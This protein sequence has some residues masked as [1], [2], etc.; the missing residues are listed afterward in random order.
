M[1]KPIVAVVQHKL[2]VTKT[3]DELLTYYHRFLRIAKTKGSKLV[4]FPEFSGLAVGIPMLPG[5][6]NALLKE[7]ATPKSGLLPKLKGMLAGGAANVVRADL[8]KSLLMTLEQMPE[9]LLDIYISVFSELA[10]QYE[11]TLV[12]GSLYVY[13]EEGAAIRHAAYVFG[14]DGAVL[15]RQMQV[16][17]DS[18]TLPV[19]VPGTG[20]QPIETSVG[21]LGILFAHEALY[22]EPARVLAYQG[23]DILITIA[24]TKRPAI[25]HKV[26]QGAL[27]RCQENQLYGLVSFLVG[28]DPFA[29]SDD[30]PLFLG[31]STIFAPLDFT[32]RFTG[33]MTELGSAQAEG[34]VTAEWDFPALHELWES[35]E[36]PIRRVMPL[37][38]VGLLAQVY[39]RALT[40]ETSA[41]SVHQIGAEELSEPFLPVPS[42]AEEPLAEPEASESHEAHPTPL[43]EDDLLA[44]VTPILPTEPPI[45]ALADGELEV[46]ETAVTPEDGDAVV[47]TEVMESEP[48]VSE[49]AMP[50]PSEMD[51]ET[52][53]VTA[54]SED[55]HEPGSSSVNND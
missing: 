37:E 7:A 49:D 46:D 55:E 54:F 27:A 4:V 43:D 39:G 22:P 35:T 42:E 11:I 14:P 29:S 53:D 30:E 1:D 51:E 16:V 40:L 23:A 31:K 8:Q 6:R 41:Q 33:V 20:W 48:A 24:A 34:V 44:V 17:P 13:D 28:Q 19:V 12:A 18:E 38:Q 5:W 36:T 47:E 2:I 9:S 26:R 45:I 32:S 25:Y 3:L 15:G 52:F 50:D 21:R 10:R